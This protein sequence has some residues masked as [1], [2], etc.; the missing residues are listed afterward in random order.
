MNNVL[1]TIDKEGNK[2]YM[3]QERWKHILRHPHMHNGIEAIQK[4]LKNPTTTR[5]FEQDKK[6]RHFYKE[7]KQSEPSE[8][9]LLVVVKYLN[10]SGFII[11]GLKWKLI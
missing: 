8:K 4:T 7:F 5:H 6:V 11:T 3:S 9:Y 1:E 10:G 2:I